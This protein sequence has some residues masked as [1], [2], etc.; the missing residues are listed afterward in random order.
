M[1]GYVWICVD[2]CFF[3][4]KPYLL[5]HL[6]LKFFTFK[7][8]CDHQDL[9]RKRQ[10]EHQSQLQSCSGNSLFHVS[11]LAGHAPCCALLFLHYSLQLKSSW[12]SD[13]LHWAQGGIEHRVNKPCSDLHSLSWIPVI[14]FLTK[15][16]PHCVG[17][18][19]H[20]HK[21]CVQLWDNLL[22]SV[23]SKFWGRGYY[24]K[25]NIPMCKCKI[26][27]KLNIHTKSQVLLGRGKGKC[28]FPP[29]QWG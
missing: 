12:I 5:L 4:R 14:N 21:V 25:T 22:F 18:E 27:L 7:V 13:E 29:S 26:P 24:D 2:I 28:H 6:C 9:F 3:Y 16:P 1:C 8:V 19:K 23:S 20:L 10:E 15:K 17:Q 11:H